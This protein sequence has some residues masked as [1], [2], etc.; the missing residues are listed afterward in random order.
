MT[1]LKRA[2]GPLDIVDDE[3]A[4]IFE[5]K[6]ARRKKL[7]ALPYPEKVKIVVELQR[8]T[9]PILRARGI[10]VRV[11]DIEDKQPIVDEGH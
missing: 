7:A 10:Q 3:V 2:L 5:E 11:W 6:E 1:R 8:L 4:R 9:A